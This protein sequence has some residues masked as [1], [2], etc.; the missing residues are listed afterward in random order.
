[1]ATREIVFVRGD[2]APPLISTLRDAAGVKVLTLATVVLVLRHQN[3][4]VTSIPCDLVTGGSTGKVSVTW[5]A[6]N[7][8]APGRYQ[9]EYRVTYAD[10]STQ[11]FPSRKPNTLVIREALA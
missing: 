3:G 8:P 7:Q 2:T 5:T 6:M 10:S 1:M 11:T 9:A 4:T